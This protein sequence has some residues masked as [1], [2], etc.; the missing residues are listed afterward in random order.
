MFSL[1]ILISISIKKNHYIFF[2]LFYFTSNQYT[3][4][5][6]EEHYKIADSTSNYTQGTNTVGELQSSYFTHRTLIL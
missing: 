3:R 2:S 5:F 1:Q 6:Y 4:H